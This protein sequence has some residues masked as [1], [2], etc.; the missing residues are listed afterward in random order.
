M[1]DDEQIVDE[2]QTERKTGRRRSSND[3]WWKTKSEE[4]SNVPKWGK[5]GIMK[6]K[7]EQK[8]EEEIPTV[9]SNSER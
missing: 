3:V 9:K 5:I 7:N 8:A 6:M 1:S 4:C 2:E